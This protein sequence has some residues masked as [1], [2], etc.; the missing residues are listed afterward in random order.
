MAE[1]DDLSSP[2]NKE[3]LVTL[4]IGG[5]HYTTYRS[6]LTKYPQTLLGRMFADDQK[7][8][9]EKIPFFDRSDIL[10]D[11]ILNFYRTDLLI[12]PESVTHDM[13]QAEL[14]F[15]G[16][17]EVEATPE[18]KDELKDLKATLVKVIANQDLIID[19]VKGLS[20][21]IVDYLNIYYTKENIDP[22]SFFD[23]R[24]RRY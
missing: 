4:N 18:L 9:H 10:F 2:E 23:E 24:Y 11:A 12:K 14:G 5:K 7:L 3:Q 8:G 19:H 15:W 16:L 1:N 13:W 21:D 22:E 20:H 6:T 17:P